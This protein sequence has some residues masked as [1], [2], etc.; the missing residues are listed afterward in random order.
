MRPTM[1]VHVHRQNLSTPMHNSITVW[2]RKISRRRSNRKVSWES[3]HADNSGKEEDE[4]I[5]AADWVEEEEE[6]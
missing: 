4:E 1:R 2:L 6:V 5:R 3:I